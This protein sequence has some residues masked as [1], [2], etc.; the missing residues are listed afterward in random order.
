VYC[1]FEDWDGLRWFN[2]A[3]YSK[4]ILFTQGYRFRER[5]EK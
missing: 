4:R 1:Y 5:L 2:L 3:G